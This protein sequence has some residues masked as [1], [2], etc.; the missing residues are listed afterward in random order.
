MIRR[1]GEAAGAEGV[2]A[3]VALE[4]EERKREQLLSLISTLRQQLHGIR[5]VSPGRISSVQSPAGET[6][7]KS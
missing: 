1:R 7:G 3:F 4:L 5:C 2:R 6:F